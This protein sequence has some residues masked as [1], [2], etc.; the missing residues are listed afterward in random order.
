M[1]EQYLLIKT[2]LKACVDN[3]KEKADYFSKKFD[4]I[5][6]YKFTKALSNEKFNIISICTPDHTQYEITKIIL[7]SEK[8]DI[9]FLEKPIV[10]T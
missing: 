4:C 10:I 3:D 5:S 2:N 1:Q 8:T 9:I 6:L 7:N